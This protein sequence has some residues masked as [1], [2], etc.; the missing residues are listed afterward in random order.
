V[1]QGLPGIFTVGEITGMST[2]A[3]YP[4]VSYNTPPG[5]A[6]DRLTVPPKTKGLSG[7]LLGVQS[8]VVDELD[9][10]WILDTGRVID[11]SDP[12]HAMLQSQPGGP[13]LVAVDLATN[14]VRRALPSRPGFLL[15][16]IA[17]DDAVSVSMTDLGRHAQVVKTIT[18]P[19]D[20]V[21]PFSYINDVRI[22]RS[23][24]LSG[25][26]GKEGAAYVSP[27]LSRL[28]SLRPSP[29]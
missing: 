24:N 9:T 2:E 11:F 26:S 4:N 7:Y 18:F 29:L 13:K 14:K 10:L 6:V 12:L 27:P 5:G 8:V 3:A 20:V 16:L 19:A 22:D 21:L 17:A 25:I 15:S 28:H 1:N 23:P